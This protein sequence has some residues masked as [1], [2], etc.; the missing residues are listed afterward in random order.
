[1]SGEAITVED[2]INAL[3]VAS[4]FV[5]NQLTLMSNNRRLCCRIKSVTGSVSNIIKAIFSGNIGGEA[6]KEFGN[7][8]SNAGKAILD[9]AN[10][11]LRDA[12]FEDITK[13]L[14]E[15]C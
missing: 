10:E 8:G 7:M 9:G 4:D 2:V 12:K 11:S 1:M 5:T 6:V 3:G 15:N 13:A 14:E